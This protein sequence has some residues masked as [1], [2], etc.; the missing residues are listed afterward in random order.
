MDVGGDLAQVHLLGVL[1]ETLRGV[2][3]V[4]ARRDDVLAGVAE[5]VESAHGDEV[6]QERDRGRDLL[7]DVGHL[8]LDHL[9]ILL[10]SLIIPKL[11]HNCELSSR[12]GAEGSDN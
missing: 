3:P 4:A 6:R 8:G 7:D 1:D 5:H 2:G 10:A 12:E 11:T 9:L